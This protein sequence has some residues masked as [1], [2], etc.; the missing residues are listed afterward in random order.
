[1]QV[2][3]HLLEVGGLRGST[4]TVGGEGLGRHSQLLRHG[5]DSR[6][7]RRLELIGCEPSIPQR[8]ELESKAQACLGLTVL[9]DHLV[10]GL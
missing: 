9:V 4:C 2:G 8:T 10:I 7:R 5:L 6:R 3:R 1:M